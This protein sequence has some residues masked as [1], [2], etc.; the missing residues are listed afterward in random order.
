MMGIIN[1]TKRRTIAEMRE[2]KSKGL[3]GLSEGEKRFYMKKLLEKYWF[4]AVL[5]F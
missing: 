5:Q 2:S 4:A 1:D 3:H